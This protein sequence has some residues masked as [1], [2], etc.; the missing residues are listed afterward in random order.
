MS[1]LD[2]FFIVVFII[3]MIKGYMKGLVMEVFSFVGFFIGLFAAIKLTIPVSGTFF[4]G[5]EYFQFLTIGVFI[6][7]FVLVVLAVGLLGKILK[8]AIDITFLGFFDNVLGAL[9][10]LLKWAFIFS[11]I[12][13]VFDSIGMR[14]SEEWKNGSFIYPIVEVIGPKVFDWVSKVMPFVKDMIDSLENIGDKSKSVYS[15][16]YI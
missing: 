4:E 3:G 8:K 13:W 1:Y 15:F 6:I 11:V 9:A 16:L 5:T 10:S 2:I 12:I 7:L 14:I